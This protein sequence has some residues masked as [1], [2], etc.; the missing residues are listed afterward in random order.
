MAEAPDNERD[1]ARVVAAR[2]GDQ[3]AYA[4]LLRAH[5]GSVF[6]V[7]RNNVGAESDALDL[8][9]EVFA[10]AFAAL[11][12]FDRTRSFRTWILRIAV[13]KCHD[14]AR[15]RA[16]R[17][18]FTFARPIDEALSVADEGADP[19]AALTSRQEIER[20]RRAIASLPNGI[21][22]PLILC[23]IEGMPQAEAAQV[24]NISEKA[25]ETR[26]YR[27]KRRLDALLAS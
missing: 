23:A 5:R 17:R 15:R 24:L 11:A 22:E 27:A 10:A 6:R 25:V 9:Q 3:A 1:A 2:A 8:T 26:I 12:S 14:W 20:L 7:C 16:V 19:E 18:F 13:N 4:E 21:R